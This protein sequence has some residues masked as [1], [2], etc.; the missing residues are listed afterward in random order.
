MLGDVVR[1]GR[2]GTLSG[3]AT[4]H[5]SLG[6]VAF[7]ELTPNVLHGTIPV[8]QKLVDQVWD[9]GNQNFRPTS[10]Q[11]SNLNVGTG[12]DNVI[13]GE[14]SVQFNFRY[15]T[16]QKAESLQNFVIESL[17]SLKPTFTYEPDWRHG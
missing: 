12:A 1:V 14:L 9:S 16:E 7:P 15:N 6:H 11:I 10:F 4:I 17:N 2:R 3:D 8:L 13:P 5:G